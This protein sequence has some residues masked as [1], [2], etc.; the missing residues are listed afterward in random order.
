[1]YE[2]KLDFYLKSLRI[3]SNDEPRKPC[4]YLKMCCN[5]F[6]PHPGH[7]LIAPLLSVAVSLEEETYFETHTP[8]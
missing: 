5:L 1:M 3:S 2:L 7:G 4:T 6:L 8:F